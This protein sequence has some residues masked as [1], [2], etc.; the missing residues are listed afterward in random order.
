MIEVTVGNNVSRS[1]VIVDPSLSL[2]RV[3]EDNEINYETSVMQLDGASLS[4]G[5]LE[6]SFTDFGVTEKCFLLSVV[7]TDVA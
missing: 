2:K 6:K 4:A 3:L 1:K 5:D 7:K